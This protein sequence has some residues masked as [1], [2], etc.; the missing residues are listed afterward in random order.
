MTP[1]T[2]ALWIEDVSNICRGKIWRWQVKSCAYQSKAKIEKISDAPIHS[3]QMVSLDVVS[4]FT[5]VPTDETLAVVR[6]KLAADPL[7]EERTCIPID[8]LMEMLTFCVETTYFGMG[9][10]IYRQEEGLAMGSPLSPVLANLYMEYFE[11]MALGSTSLKP[12]MWLRYVDDTFILWPHQEDVQILLDHVNSI[13]PSIPFTMEKEQDNKL[14]FLDV[15]VT[16]TEQGFRSSVYRKPTFTGQYLNFN[17]HHPYTVKKGIVRCLQ[18]RAKTISSD[19]DAYQEEMISLGHNPHHNNNPER[20]TSAPRNLDRRVEDNTRKL[21]TV[22]LPYVKGLA[23]RIKKI[24]SPY[25]IRTVFTSGS[26]L[27]RYLF[28]VKPPKEFNMTKNCVYS[29]PCSCV[30]IYRGETGRPQKVR[31]EE[32]RKAIVRGEIEKSGMADHIWKENGNHLPLWDKV[33]IIDWAEHWRIRRLKESAYML[34]YND[35]LSRPSIEL[36][37]IWEPIIK[38]A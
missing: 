17:S 31:L 22:C 24:C 3:N 19:T 38:K 37:T 16:R 23:E 13:R 26:T 7:L 10:D 34:G 28:R 29:I 1:I 32:H 33:E 2:S 12:S 20:I 36:N 5:K 6:D 30:K 8:N 9:F 25:D 14:P 27:R 11:E 15:L 4:L 35:L 21:T 18:H